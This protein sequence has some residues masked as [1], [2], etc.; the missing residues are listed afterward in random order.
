MGC[1]ALKT[2]DALARDFTNGRWKGV[3]HFYRG[4]ALT[5]ME[6][7]RWAEAAY[8][9]APKNLLTPALHRLATLNGPAKTP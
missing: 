5:A 3:V 6:K 4:E 8:R 7:G 9:A 1:S 2:L